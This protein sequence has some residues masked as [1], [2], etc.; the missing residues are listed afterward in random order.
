MKIT[1]R[2]THVLRRGVRVFVRSDNH[3]GEHRGVLEGHQQPGGLTAPAARSAKTAIAG[4]A[5]AAVISRQG[6]RRW[7]RQ[8]IHGIMGRSRGGHAGEHERR[9]V[10]GDVRPDRVGHYASGDGEDAH[11]EEHDQDISM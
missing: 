7:P 8:R 4:A 2:R 5:M 3:H 9:I 11:A 10:G 6:G 1:D